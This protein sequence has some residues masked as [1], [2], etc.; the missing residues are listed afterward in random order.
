MKRRKKGRI[1]YLAAFIT[2]L[3]FGT[4]GAIVI[5]PGSGNAV[6]IAGCCCAIPPLMMLLSFIL[7]KRFEKK[8]KSASAAELQTFILSHR[9]AAERP[10]RKSSVCCAALSVSWMLPQFSSVSAAQ[11]SRFSTA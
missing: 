7:T 1:I 11:P 2:T 6:L 8:F 5:R 4:L 9:E 10:R 3:A